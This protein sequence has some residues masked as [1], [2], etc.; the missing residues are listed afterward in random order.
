LLD[1]LLLLM[2][3]DH[4]M[5]DLVEQHQHVEVACTATLKVRQEQL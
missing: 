1:S 3:F 2:L 5:F 4:P